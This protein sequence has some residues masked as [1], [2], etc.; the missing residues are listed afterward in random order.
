MLDRRHS[1]IF[2]PADTDDSSLPPLASESDV[3]IPCEAAAHSVQ[4]T[5]CR[6]LIRHRPIALGVRDRRTGA[7]DRRADGGC[8]LIGS[9]RGDGGYGL[10][11]PGHVL[12]T[13]IG[14]LSW[15]GISHIIAS[16]GLAATHGSARS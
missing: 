5:Q 8:L 6:R 10:A 1:L 12:D 3:A 13:G 7:A 2:R 16:E 4:V 15:R 9:R 11:A 14:G